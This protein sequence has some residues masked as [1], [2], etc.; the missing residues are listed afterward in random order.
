VR[1][2]AL[3]RKQQFGSEFFGSRNKF[4]GFELELDLF[5]EKEVGRLELLEFGEPAP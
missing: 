3:S 5:V 1:R 2:A 4:L